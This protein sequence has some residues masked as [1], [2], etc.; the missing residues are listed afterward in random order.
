M[1]FAVLLAGG[2][3]SRAGGDVPKQF[4]KVNNIPM[5]AYCFET[6]CSSVHTDVC[7]VVCENI[8]ES[9]IGECF[10]PGKTLIF[11]KPGKTRQ[12]SILNALEKI[13]VEFDTKE[14]TVMVYDAARPFVSSDLIDSMYSAL[15]DHD[16]VM[17]V[18]P[19]KDTVY[20]CKNGKISGLL[21]RSAIFAGQA[22]ELFV[23]DKYY[24]A[25]A[26]LLDNGIEK[27]NGSSEPA[28]MAGMDIVTVPGD[29]KNI[30]ITTSKDLED[31]INACNS[32]K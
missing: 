12:L 13:R 25:N 4:V 5:I 28:I 27:I 3:G 16:G 9:V 20:E 1:N 14:S 30:K 10:H 7:V 19:M 8:Y 31:F 11:A 23:F 21:D 15:K 24:E 17:P 18:L 29:E 6:L 26:A 22:P 32:F 2:T